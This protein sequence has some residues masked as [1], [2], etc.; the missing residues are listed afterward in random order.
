MEFWHAGVVCKPFLSASY[1]TIRGKH[2]QCRKGSREQRSQRGSGLWGRSA[3][4]A[5]CRRDSHHI[6]GWATT[7][8]PQ[9]SSRSTA[10]SWAPPGTHRKEAES[11][12]WRQWGLLRAHIGCFLKRPPFAEHSWVRMAARAA[13][14]RPTNRSRQ[15]DVTDHGAAPTPPRCALR[16]AALRTSRRWAPHSAAERRCSQRRAGPGPVLPH[17]GGLCRSENQALWGNAAL[18]GAGSARGS[19]FLSQPC[20]NHRKSW[21]PEERCLSLPA[22]FL[23]SSRVKHCEKKEERTYIILLS[24]SFSHSRIPMI[25]AP[26]AAGLSPHMQCSRGHRQQHGVGTPGGDVGLCV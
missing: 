26:R 19:L 11:H 24:S 20:P 6:R 25:C 5:R 14:A 2:S 3:G 22:S 4:R 18:S 23:S 10:R 21:C 7:E 17:A 15:R 9:P 16:G 12:R 13:A 1:R 8:Q